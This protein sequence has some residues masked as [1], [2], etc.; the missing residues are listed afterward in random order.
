MKIK[1]WWG[2]ESCSTICWTFV[3]KRGG[4]VGGLFIRLCWE[5]KWALEGPSARRTNECSALRNL[6]GRRALSQSYMTPPPFMKFWCHLV[7]RLSTALIQIWRTRLPLWV[8][9]VA[10][11]L[12]SQVQAQTSQFP[13]KA[14]QKCMKPPPQFTPVP[15]TPRHESC[16]HLQRFGMMWHK[17]NR[18]RYRL[19]E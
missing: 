5:G 6:R 16:S 8:F 3:P 18:G 11:G 12:D 10:P 13:A 9:H 2:G 14:L 4:V 1:W 15:R 7:Q 17:A 19:A